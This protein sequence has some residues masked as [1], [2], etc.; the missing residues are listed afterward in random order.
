MRRECRERFPSHWLQRKP[1]VSDHGMH[2]DTCVTHVPWW[3][4]GSLTSDGMENVPDIPGIPDAYTT[5]NFAYLTK[6]PWTDVG[7]IGQTKLSY[8]N[9]NEQLLRVLNF[10]GWIMWRNP[11]ARLLYLQCC[12]HIGNWIP[13]AKFDKT[14]T[15]DALRPYI[16]RL[17][18]WW[19][20]VNIPMF[21]N[22]VKFGTRTVSAE[23]SH[24]I[25]I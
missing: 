13:W 7:R 1:L 9:F 8:F 4:S 6:G 22:Q 16:V 21:I 23:E 19:Y 15:A 14:V 2:H 24:K 12:S 18:E 5:R 17:S 20:K 3:M 10:T 25:Q 11:V